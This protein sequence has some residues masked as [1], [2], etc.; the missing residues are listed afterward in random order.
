MLALL[1]ALR[2]GKPALLAT[3]TVYGVAALPGSPGVDAIFKLKERPAGQALPWL[4]AGEEWLDRYAQDVPPYARALC[5]ELWPGALTVV[6]R[7][8]AEALRLGG[9]QEDGTVAL[10][11]PGSPACLSVLQE[12]DAPLACTSANVHGL[13]APSR[14]DQ[15]DARFTALAHATDIAPAC[16]AGLAS[17][18]VDCTGPAPRILREG[19]VSAQVVTNTARLDAKL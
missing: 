7:A 14:L 4:V 16:P 5:A 15:V 11:C 18:V 1:D 12:L 8:S 9:L 6:L 10:R 3:D 19:A 17:T 13:P 2:E